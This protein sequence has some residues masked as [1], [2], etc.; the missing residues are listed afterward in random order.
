M[1]SFISGDAANKG[2]KMNAWAQESA[3]EYN[4]Q[5]MEQ[6]ARLVAADARVNAQRLNHNKS[7]AMSSV[8]A[9]NAA[10]GLMGETMDA[11]S[12]SVAEEYETARADMATAAER[13]I[14]KLA[15]NAAM[16]RWQ[17]KVGAEV[18]RFE[19][20]ASKAAGMLSGTAELVG[21]ATG[22]YGLGKSFG[23]WGK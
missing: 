16:S 14:A 1:G 3:G 11:R 6:E 12:V 23:M 19:G 5:L 21:V 17:G 9:A 22:G 2:A 4:A 7:A 20:R 18:S 8:G 13:E 10:S 15:N